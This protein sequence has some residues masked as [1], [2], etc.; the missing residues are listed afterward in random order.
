SAAAPAPA[1]SAAPA[2]A[3]ASAPAP[4][5]GAPRR[6]ATR[7]AGW[8][9]A[10]AA[11]ALLAAGS[12]AFARRPA[13]RDALAPG[14][15]LFGTAVAAL[16]RLD[17]RDGDGFAAPPFGADCDDHNRA[18]HPG[19]LD[20]PGNRVDED[21]DGADLAAAERLVFPQDWTPLPAALPAA[22]NV[23][24]V[25][26]D[27]LRADYTEGTTGA[28]L[29]PALTAAAAGMVRFTRAYA[30]STRSLRSIP[31]LLTGRYPPG[32]HFGAEPKYPG[33]KPDNQSLP[34]LL[35]AASGGAFDADAFHY[36][37]YFLKVNGFLQGWRAHTLADAPPAVREMAEGAARA[38]LLTDRAIEVLA[39]RDPARR[40]AAWVHYTD[41]H[42]PYVDN[43]RFRFGS[44]D[45]DRYAAEVAFT[46]AAVGRLLAWLDRAGLA[47]TT[48][49]VFAADHGEEF[50]EH[51]NRFHGLDLYDEE[52]RVPLLVRAAGAAPH[53][54]PA[55][56]TLVDV[57]PTVLNLLGLSRP[58]GVTFH[59]RSLVP[60]L[61]G[62][63]LAARAGV[64][65]D[66]VPDGDHPQDMRAVIA[67]DAK[68]I[69]DLRTGR[70]ELYD[71]AADPGER[72]DLAAA[73][74]ARVAALRRL[75][76]GWRL[77]AG[78][79]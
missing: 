52:L 34:E 57:A 43:D 37:R 54:V 71:L 64:F 22:R 33:F 50:G 8:I 55:P 47:A 6:G 74:P 24:L 62:A 29:M 26:V 35:A 27:T 38:E 79:K 13:L 1:R 56:V 10:A 31:A 32:I 18:V 49:V 30:P 73:D 45:R 16:A 23:L 11:A 44:D 42:Y 70:V 67:G 5:V 20:V 14:L 15:P 46:D 3:S 9:L 72:R 21:C 78:G 75:L 17:D 66:L 69:E 25:T 51:G 7:R 77:G 4:A 61:A 48:L 41:P 40:F 60:A 58:A 65:A 19:A 63:P 28:R 53:E 2:S 36:S 12:A 59:G 76:A 39:A 68:L